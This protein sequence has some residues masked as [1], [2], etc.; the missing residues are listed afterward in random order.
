[1]PAEEKSILVERAKRLIAEYYNQGITLEEVAEKLSV[2]G[3]YL[4]TR[5][6]KETGET[7]SE[8]IRRYRIDK[9]KELLI[10][11]NLKLNQIA[12]RAGY[13]NPKYM[14]KVFKEETGLLPLEYRKR[15]S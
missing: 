6:K 10:S 2:S 9:V 5:I 1:M 14:S 12:V 3:E 13:T 11:T 7:F 4:S 8:I 15:N